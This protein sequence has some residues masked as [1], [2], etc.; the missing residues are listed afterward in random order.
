MKIL[1]L[2][3]DERPCNYEYPQMICDISG[4][5]EILLPD[6]EILSKKKK[7]ANISRIWQWLDD[8]GD[9]CDA[10]VLSIEMLVYG[11]LLPSRI[12]NMSESLCI[13]RVKRLAQWKQK[14][15]DVKVYVSNLIMRTPS[16]S[17]N[18]EEP[19]YYEQ[20]G[21]MIFRYGWLKDK[22]NRQKLNEEEKNELKYLSNNI[23]DVVI[24]DY[25][26][27]RRKNIK[28]N[29][30]ILHLVKEK[31]IDFLVIPQDDSAPYGYTAIDQ[32]LIAD[33]ITKERLQFRVQT[34]PGA[35]EAGCTLVSKAFTDYFNKQPHVYVTYSSTLGAQIIPK[36]EDR[37]FGESVKA[38]ILAA[39]AC[40]TEDINQADIVLMVNSPGKLM[41]EAW[42]Q[43][44]KDITYNSFRNLID[45]V[46]KIDMYLKQGK[47]CI[48]ADIAFSNGADIE[49]IA[50]MDERK[51]L[52]KIHAYAGWNTACN[53]LG[54][55][56]ASGI[57]GLYNNSDYH[58]LK[59]MIYR[60]M[61]DWSYQAIV[62]QNTINH[63]LPLFNATFYEF[64]GCED[65]ICNSICEQLQEIWEKQ[66]KYSFRD[67]KV[68]VERVFTPWHRM[69]EIGID[70]TIK[71]E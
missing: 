4:N 14:N 5:I 38:H 31:I 66:I 26:E 53:T 15:P 44:T 65:N 70:L 20:Y 6:I 13:E 10:A 30:E 48:I 9:K 1:Y 61:E 23:P 62:R 40:I 25:E 37:P 57:V 67:W 41:Q 7:A 3:L 34:Y 36:Y 69:F 59:N 19:D 2:P 21:E 60:L 64:K 54:T 58:R 16:Y 22:Q 32:R 51:L 49:L 43:N 52:D 68:K 17:S 24:N 50:M 71:K 12:H 39:G 45:F 63:V 29:M 8:N 28:V 47:K 46:D 55:V 42:E 11:G 35:D 27:R 18:E 33:I 56:L